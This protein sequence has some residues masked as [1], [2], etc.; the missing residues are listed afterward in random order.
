MSSGRASAVVWLTPTSGSLPNLATVFPAAAEWYQFEA[1]LKSAPM[2]S[3]A[4]TG[5][6]TPPS[7]G[8]TRPE[9]WLTGA[10]MATGSYSF[11]APGSNTTSRTFPPEEAPLLCFQ[12]VM[13]QLPAGTV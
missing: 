10:A 2:T 4:S 9:P 11:A 12:P 6:R 1:P 8:P 5:I 13:I 3:P 7:S